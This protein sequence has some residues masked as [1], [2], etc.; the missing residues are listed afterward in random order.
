MPSVQV[1]LINIPPKNSSKKKK[2]NHVGI[3]ALCGLQ[4]FEKN[5]CPCV[6]K[7]TCSSRKKKVHKRCWCRQTTSKEHKKGLAIGK[8]KRHT[9]NDEHPPCQCISTSP[10]ARLYFFSML[11]LRTSKWRHTIGKSVCRHE[12]KGTAVAERMDVWDTCPCFLYKT[13]GKAL[14]F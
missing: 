7:N 6:N 12:N 10:E 11:V 3:A 9:S 8:K 1:K 5:I 2:K 4:G 14:F 13:I